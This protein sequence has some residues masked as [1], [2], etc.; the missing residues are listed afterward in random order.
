MKKESGATKKR[1]K[2]GKKPATTVEIKVAR[3]PAMEPANPG[4]KSAS[5]VKK[6]PQGPEKKWRNTA[7]PARKEEK[8]A[9]FWPADIDLKGKPGESPRAL[10][11]TQGA[12]LSQIT[13]G[14]IYGDVSVEWSESIPN[15]LK[16]TATF[17]NIQ[18]SLHTDKYFVVHLR[19]VVP[20]LNSYPDEA[21]MVFHGFDPYP[22]IVYSQYSTAGSKK[23]LCKN[24]KEYEEHVA[25]LLGSEKMK[26]RIQHLIALVS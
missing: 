13:G 12:Y 3:R 22:C 16:N 21:L 20:D 10:L 17:N 18:S 9:P 24:R 26:T 6:S 14:I 23:T 11:E 19:L 25:F 8:T 7:V 2:P 5:A 1:R 4:K 15:S